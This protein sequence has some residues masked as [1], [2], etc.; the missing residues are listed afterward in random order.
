ME[1]ELPPQSREGRWLFRRQLDE[2]AFA[3]AHKKILEQL[4]RDAG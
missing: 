2:L 1:H 4:R 3:G